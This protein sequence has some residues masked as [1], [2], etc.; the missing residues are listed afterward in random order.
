MPGYGKSLEN[1]DFNSDLTKVSGEVQIY[2][3]ER[4]IKWKNEKSDVPRDC[5]MSNS[6]SHSFDMPE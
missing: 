6:R 3:K 2:V 5:E 1:G 4:D